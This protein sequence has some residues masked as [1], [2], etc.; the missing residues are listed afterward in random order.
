MQAEILEQQ[1]QGGSGAGTS[2]EETAGAKITGERALLSGTGER[3]SVAGAVARMQEGAGELLG[4]GWGA[5]SQGLR[6]WGQS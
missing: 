5:I 1:G 6:P 4:A 3:A 2:G